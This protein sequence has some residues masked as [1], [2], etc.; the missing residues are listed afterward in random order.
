[1]NTNKILTLVAAVLAIVG[2]GVNAGV[3]LDNVYDM[4]MSGLFA[5]ILIVALAGAFMGGAKSSS[6]MSAST[7]QYKCNALRHEL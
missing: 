6:P 5:V 2:L 1:M 7:Q 4:T 3:D